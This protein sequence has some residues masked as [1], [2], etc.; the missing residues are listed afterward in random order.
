MRPVYLALASTLWVGLSATEPAT[1]PDTS[2]HLGPVLD[3][4]IEVRQGDRVVFEGLS[5]EMSIRGWDR[6]AI[7]IA[8]DDDD[9]RVA[10]QRRG[11]TIEIERDDRKGRSRDFEAY[12]RVPRWMDV[13]IRGRNLD[14]RLEDL[15]SDV[16]V[17]TVS[18]D[19]SI[20]RV[21]G[22]LEVRTVEG[23][24]DVMGA[25]GGVSVSSQS[26]DVWL[27]DI[28]GRVEAHSGSGDLTLIDVA[29]TSVRAET[30]D[31][32]VTFSGTID[33]GGVYRF[34]VHDGDADIAIPSSTNANVSVSTF[35]GDFHS[36][37]PVRLDRFTGGRA[38][39]FSIGSGGARI[40]IQVFDGEIN[41]LE[42]DR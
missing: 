40:E 8:G 28:E 22:A 24:V 5:G 21:Q 16:G 6:D 25:Y 38:F 27:R 20:E 14:L 42:R 4:I 13:E 1:R 35:D 2:G 9:S 29:S 17:R 7:E 18:G 31:G 19:I 10:V 12:V 33:D 41:I 26:D 15:D 23:E 39:D 32:D 11:S 37:F 30:Q 34:F 36:D 3:T